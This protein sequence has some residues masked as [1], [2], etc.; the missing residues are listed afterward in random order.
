MRCVLIQTLNTLATKNQTVM[1]KHTFLMRK[2]LRNSG[3]QDKKES[4]K[5]DSAEM[6]VDTDDDFIKWSFGKDPVIPERA[7]TGVSGSL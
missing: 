2:N 7:F 4:K 1:M 5:E 6:D 3:K